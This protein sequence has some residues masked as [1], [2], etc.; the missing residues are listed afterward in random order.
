MKTVVPQQTTQ[1]AQAAEAAV[2][3]A[4][5]CDI[6]TDFSSPGAAA[7]GAAG[8]VPDTIPALRA[9]GISAA[10][11]A[12]G[13]SGTTAVPTPP[14]AGGF[15]A[16]ASSP[17]AEEAGAFAL[18]QR[19]GGP[20]RPACA[21]PADDVRATGLFE[22]TYRTLLSTTSRDLDDAACP[23]GRSGGGGGGGGGSG[24]GGHGTVVGLPSLGGERRRRR[25]RHERSGC[26]PR[27][28]RRLRHERSGCEPRRRRWRDGRRGGPSA[29]VYSS[30][31]GQGLC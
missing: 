1:P 4:A 18:A 24:G 11:A 16:R 3:G 6:S 26:E 10:A 14:A 29:L 27:R 21:S 9:S 5:S 31:L 12:A 28:W 20:Q 22:T 13:A 17:S 15:P 19:F 2:A 23:S 25:L 8:N 30:K 7:L